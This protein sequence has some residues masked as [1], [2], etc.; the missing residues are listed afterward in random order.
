MTSH[1]KIFGSGL[2]ALDMVVGAR[3]EGPI[4]TWAG[5]TCGNVLSILAWLEWS[6]FPIARM[7][8]DAASQRI[9]T[10]MEH[11]GIH[12]DWTSCAP[13]SHTP[14]IVQ[15]IVHRSDGRRGHR[16]SWSCLHCGERLPGFK[17]VTVASAEKIKPDISGTSVFFFDRVSRAALTLAAEAS[18]RGAV[19]VFEPSVSGNGRLMAEAISL[20]HIVKYAEGRTAHIGRSSS[21][22]AGPLLEVHTLGERGLKYRHRFGRGVSDWIY[23]KAFPVPRLADA[24]G[25][26]DWCTAGLIAKTAVEGQRGLRRAGASGVDEALIY[27]QA[28]AAWNCSFEGARGGMYAVDRAVFDKQINDLVNDGHFEG[29]S[30]AP[31]KDDDSAQSVACPACLSV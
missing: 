29:I 21:E 30:Y 19:V 31:A 22:G 12:L 20:A 14:I 16:F 7:N 15:E 5:G 26:G 1:A 9:R 2:I 28:L 8:G 6:A 10:D 3:S 24:C 17:A 13:T 11:W 4:R 25:S 27:G 23:Q 18:A